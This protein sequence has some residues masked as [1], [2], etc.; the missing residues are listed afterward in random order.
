[1]FLCSVR[2]SKLKIFAIF[3]MILAAGITAIIVIT[4]ANS[5][6]KPPESLP[7]EEMMAAETGEQRVA[8]LTYFGWEVVADPTEVAEVTIPA[9]FDDV[10]QN[11]NAIQ[12]QQGLD[13]EAYKGQTVT[14]YT[15]LITNYPEGKSNVYAH[16]LVFENR[17]VGGDVCSSELDG[18]MH[19]F[20][21]P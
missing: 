16:I 4:N 7:P 19:G 13:L 12:K 1:M 11:Y 21:Q 17:I 8:F 15:Y 2:M 18:F 3:A 9:E 10:Y 20:M 14:R 6:S 5:G